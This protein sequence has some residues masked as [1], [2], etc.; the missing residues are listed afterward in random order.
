[1]WRKRGFHHLAK[2]GHRHKNSPQSSMTH[3]LQ[4]IATC[5]HSSHSGTMT[6]TKTTGTR[7]TNICN[8]ISPK[9]WRTPGICMASCLL[10]YLM[11]IVQ[12][13]PSLAC[14]LTFSIVRAALIHRPRSLFPLPSSFHLIADGCSSAAASQLLHTKLGWTVPASL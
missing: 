9:P 14:T 2:I 7:K 4:L 8:E 10:N 13:H 6:F 3:E 5:T 1:M 12:N 11:Q